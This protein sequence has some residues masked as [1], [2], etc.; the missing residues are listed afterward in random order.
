M[1][2]TIILFQMRGMK[3]NSLEFANDCISL[4]GKF[5]G[6]LL[7]VVVGEIRVGNNHK[8]HTRTKSVQDRASSCQRIS[9]HKVSNFREQKKSLTGMADHHPKLLEVGGVVLDH[10]EIWGHVGAKFKATDFQ[11]V[12]NLATLILGT[13]GVEDVLATFAILDQETGELVLLQFRQERLM[14]DGLDE[15]LE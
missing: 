5:I 12:V 2:D 1:S 14:E 15:L 10:A 7:L 8:R 13:I 3:D 9:I 6:K 4:A 11:T